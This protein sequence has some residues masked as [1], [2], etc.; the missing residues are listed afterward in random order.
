MMRKGMARIEQGSLAFTKTRWWVNPH[1]PP[2]PH[3]HH[4]PHLFGVSQEGHCEIPGSQ[5]PH[6]HRFVP[7]PA[8]QPTV[9]QLHQS[10]HPP[11][12]HGSDRALTFALAIPY[13]ITPIKW[14]KNIVI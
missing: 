5:I 8:H 14:P 6:A 12:T 9:F 7:S 13:L 4:D 1:Q 11:P 2:P 10:T 3:H